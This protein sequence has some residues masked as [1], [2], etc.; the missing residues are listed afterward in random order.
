MIAWLLTCI[1]NFYMFIWSW[2]GEEWEDFSSS[3]HPFSK[4]RGEYFTTVSTLQAP[5]KDHIAE[6]G[7]YDGPVT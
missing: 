2:V 5:V 4:E 1:L 7:G 6:S 3:H